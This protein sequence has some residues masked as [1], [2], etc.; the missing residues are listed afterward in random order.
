[1]S[2][3]IV[4]A[5]TILL[6]LGIFGWL[7]DYGWK[8]RYGSPETYDIVEPAELS[9]SHRTNDMAMEEADVFAPVWQ[10]LPSREVT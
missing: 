7:A 5:I 2:N 9:V 6:S 3:K 8:N 10:T 4:I 1:M